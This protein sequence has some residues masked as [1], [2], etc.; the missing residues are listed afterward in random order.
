MAQG[1]ES[2]GKIMIW[3][4]LVAKL[5]L[6]EALGPV[7]DMLGFFQLIV[8]FPLIDVKFP[9]VTGIMFGALTSLVTFDVL[10]TD[11]WYPYLTG[12]SDTI[13]YTLTTDHNDPYNQAFGDFDF[14]R[15]F[16]M[17]LGSLWVVMNI[18]LIQ[19]PIYYLARC[20]N[21]YKYGRKVQDYYAESQFWG[22]PLDFMKSAYVELAYA[23][24]INWQMFAYK[25][26]EGHDL[27]L[28]INNTY[29]VL[30]TLVVIVY[31]IFLYFFM[32]HYYYNFGDEEFAAKYENMYDGIRLEDRRE[33]IWVTVLFFTRRAVLATCCVMLYGHPVFQ[34]LTLFGSQTV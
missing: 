10:P 27:G 14:G 18:T 17:N 11:D 28:W 34:F 19:F 13:W 15:F 12:G 8:Y 1:I 25:T 3:V 5:F 22:T 31:P 21:R 2:G 7:I 9:P 29:L 30:S 33:S 26:E 20:C 6:T 23:A 16:V 24:L 32:R 4:T